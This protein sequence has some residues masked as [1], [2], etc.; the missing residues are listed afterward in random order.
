MAEFERVQADRG[1]NLLILT[2]N[3]DENSQIPAESEVSPLP[4]LA[5]YRNREFAKFIGGLGKK[6]EIARG[7]ECE[8]GK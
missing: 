1:S 5:L 8:L 7:I 2:M 3:V 6:D 4:A